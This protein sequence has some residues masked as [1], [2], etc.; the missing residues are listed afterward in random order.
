MKLTSTDLIEMFFTAA[1]IVG[2]ILTGTLGVLAL[3]HL[4]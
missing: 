4:F 1:L 3:Q 2:G